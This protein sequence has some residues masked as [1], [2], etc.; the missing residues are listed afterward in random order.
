MKSDDFSMINVMLRPAFY[1][2]V[3]RLLVFG[4]AQVQAQEKQEAEQHEP[5][6][7]E[8]AVV[9]DGGAAGI[10]GVVEYFHLGADGVFRLV[11]KTV[12]ALYLVFLS[13]GCGEAENRVVYHYCAAGPFAA[14]VVGHLLIAH[15]AG[16]SFLP[17]QQQV[18]TM[19]IQAEQAAQAGHHR[20]EEEFPRSASGFFG[21][22]AE[23]RS[24]AGLVPGGQLH[25]QL[26]QNR[27]RVLLRRQVNESAGELI[28]CSMLLVAQV[29][30]HVSGAA[31][32]HP[33]YHV[34][35]YTELDDDAGASPPRGLFNDESPPVTQ[36]VRGTVR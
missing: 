17:S 12:E 2:H 34:A 5:G 20:H 7:V 6:Q 25:T 18:G 15:D 26:L 21:R 4:S 32:Q 33:A 1:Q 10:C 11:V 30:V 14:A 24:F 3:I 35:T 22:V 31:V 9:P 13:I 27:C 8:H 16:G 28:V 23:A 36:C 19:C 29:V